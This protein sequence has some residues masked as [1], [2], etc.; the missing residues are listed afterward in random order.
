MEILF[1]YSDNGENDIPE[2]TRARFKKCLDEAI[3]SIPAS[4][5]EKY[6]GRIG[7]KRLGL[8]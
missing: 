2:G 3:K 7:A 4:K 1:H 8:I 5:I 6:K